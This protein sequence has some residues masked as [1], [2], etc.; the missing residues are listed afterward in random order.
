MNAGPITAVA[1]KPD[2]SGKSNKSSDSDK[3][4]LSS[5]LSKDVYSN[6]SENRAQHERRPIMQHHFA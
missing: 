3:S 6:G 4:G 5:S 2:K 1:G